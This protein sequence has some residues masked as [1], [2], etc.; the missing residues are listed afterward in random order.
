MDRNKD[1][2]IP[3]SLWPSTH[4]ESD[5]ETENRGETVDDAVSNGLPETEK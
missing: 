3:G 1:W 4:P 2:T 5:D